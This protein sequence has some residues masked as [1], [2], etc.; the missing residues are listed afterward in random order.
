[1]WVSSASAILKPNLL[2]PLGIIVSG[3]LFSLPTIERIRSAA[4]CAACDVMRI[5]FLNFLK[6]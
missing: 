3:P 4:G 6:K 5:N 1:M 2:G